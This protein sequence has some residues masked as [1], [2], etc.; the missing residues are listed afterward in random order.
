MQE[1]EYHSN[2][3]MLASI[4]DALSKIYMFNYYINLETGEFREIAGL[5]YITAALGVKGDARNAFRQFTDTLIDD[6]YKEEFQKFVDMDTLADRLNDQQNI[7][8]EYLSIRKGWCRASFIIVK[9]DEEGIPVQVEFVVENISAEREKELEAK[10]ALEKAYEAANKANASKSAFLN[11]MSH[12]I[13][14]PMNA[15]VGFSAIASAH[16]DDRERVQD[17]ISKITAS[18]NH[19]LSIINEVLD[20]SRIESGKMHIEE[21]EVNLPAV[22]DDFLSMIQGQARGKGL[23]IDVDTTEVVHE[24][25]Y[26]DEA[27]LHRVL[28]NLGGNAV[29][30][31]PAGG[32]IYVKLFEKTQTAE[33]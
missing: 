29:K 15:I 10:E 7:S 16:I 28:L 32:R 20:M 19:L 25:V 22:F 3:R 11:N 9:R 18:S 6:N 4:I 27:R 26:A 14:T 21:Q 30:F 23:E 2:R 1:A 31:T 8:L 24:N 17:C 33:K 13:R 5:D 12:D